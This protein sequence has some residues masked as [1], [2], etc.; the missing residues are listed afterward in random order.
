MDRWCFERGCGGGYGFGRL[1]LKRRERGYVRHIKGL[2]I[3][4]RDVLWY[5]G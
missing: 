3:L 2:I 5:F 4:G 1:V